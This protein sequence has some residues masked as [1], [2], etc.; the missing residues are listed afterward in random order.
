MP[1]SGWFG[2]QSGARS[3]V[4]MSN[5]RAGYALLW[6]MSIDP[7]QAPSMRANAVRLLPSST[8]AM[9]IG[10]PISSALTRAASTTDCAALRVTLS[11]TISSFDL[12][13]DSHLQR[14]GR[15][16]RP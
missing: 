13:H 2:W 1:K 5:D 9:F 6:A 7:S 16:L 12:G 3:L 4:D 14:I 15:H 10:T 8:T 11:A